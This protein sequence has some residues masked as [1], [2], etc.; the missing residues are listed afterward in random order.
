MEHIFIIA[1][2]DKIN[3]EKEQERKKTENK[4]KLIET[5]KI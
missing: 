3:S 2:H 1:K 5:P 4:Q